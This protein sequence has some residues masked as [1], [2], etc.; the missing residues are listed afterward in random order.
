MF[1]DS[2]RHYAIVGLRWSLALIFLWFGILKALGY[3]PVYD[4]VHSTFPMLTTYWGNMGLGIFEAG[5]GFLLLIN[6]FPRLTHIVL[7]L[8]LAGTMTTLVAA[9]SLMF[10]P[11]FPI[12]T[13]AGEFVV[14]N[15]ILAMAGIAILVHEDRR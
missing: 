8:H 9:P 15:A 7:L 13:L 14:K 4:I 11:H 6:A 12:L 5:L 3:N 1:T 10:N 2:H